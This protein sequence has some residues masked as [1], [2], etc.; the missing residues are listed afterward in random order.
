MT[1]GNMILNW[2][3]ERGWSQER[4]AE[5]AGVDR[6]YISQVE[7]GRTDPGAQF[8]VAVANALRV[9]VQDL[10]AAAGLAQTTSEQERE[11]A[12]LIAANPAFEGIF[13]FARE[14]PESLPEV[15][16]YARYIVSGAPAEEVKEV[17]VAPEPRRRTAEADT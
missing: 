6:S 1:V 4:L 10:L 16:R 11:I 9:P 2:R 14:H 5:E 8:L 13:E 3:K 17:R 12:A 7:R 15:L